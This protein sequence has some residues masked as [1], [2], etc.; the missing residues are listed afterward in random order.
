MKASQVLSQAIR[1]SGV[2]GWKSHSNNV[3][4]KGT[5]HPLKNNPFVVAHV[6]RADGRVMCVG[7]QLDGTGRLTPDR[8]ILQRLISR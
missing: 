4:A 3:A 7:P 2:D 8:F 6:G 5:P 1:L